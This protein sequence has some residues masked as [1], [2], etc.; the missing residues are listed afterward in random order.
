MKK[1]LKVSSILG[2]AT[3]VKIISGAARAKFLAYTLGP[4]GLGIVGQALMYSGF[5]IQLCSLNTVFGITKAVSKNSAREKIGRVSLIV[6]TAGSLHLITSLIFMIAVLPFSK[7]LTKFIF[8]DERYQPY[9][10]GITLVTPLALYLI[11]MANPVFYGFRKIV[12][13]TKLSIMHTMIGLGLIFVLVYFYK[14]EG[15]LAQIII[16]SIIGFFLSYYYIRTK[17][18]VKPGLNFGLLKDKMSRMT[19]LYLFEYGLISFIPGNVSMLMALYLRGLFMQRY[20]VDVNGY[21]Q[22]AYAISA[23]YLPFVTN[24]VWGYFYPEMCSLKTR[25]DINQELNQFIRFAL[26]T[27][28]GIAAFTIILRKYAILILFSGK[29]MQAYNLL[30]VQAVGDIFFVLFYMFSAYFTARK[31]FGSVILISTIGYNAV[32]LLFYYFF[33]HLSGFD[34]RSLN[35]AI[36]LT[37][38]ILV[39]ICIVYMRLDTGFSL[40]WRNLTLFIKCM[41]LL[42]V[43]YAIPDSNIL[44]SAAKTAI[45]GMWLLFSITKDERRNSLKLVRTYLNGRQADER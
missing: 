20:G 9:F 10:I 5:T 41:V 21:Y 26:F 28:T 34:F 42:I 36:A 30:A 22:V 31:K 1:I 24:G 37:N 8:S 39:L 7:P 12:E 16:I 38:L 44:V 6:N 32:L 33:T 43:V 45:V 25:A 3:F 14:T 23:Y 29:F 2:V 17:T 35:L 11:G 19:S 40:V 27:A 18:P 15:M 4:G 13:Y